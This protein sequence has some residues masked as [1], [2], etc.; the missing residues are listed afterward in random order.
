MFPPL[1]ARVDCPQ[2]TQTGKHQGYP[3]PNTAHDLDSQGKEREE[4]SETN[5][6]YPLPI[7][8]CNHVVILSHPFRR[9]SFH[10]S[11]LLRSGTDQPICDTS[12][13]FKAP[14]YHV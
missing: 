3:G 10:F 2:K 13:C 9:T 12:P 11:T 6:A 7:F 1:T 5:C 4:A 14:I 8:L